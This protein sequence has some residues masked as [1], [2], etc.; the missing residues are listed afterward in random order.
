MMMIIYILYYDMYIYIIWY[1]YIYMYYGGNY[2]MDY[3]NVPTNMLWLIAYYSDIIQTIYIC[4]DDQHQQ[5]LRI[6]MS[7]FCVV[8][9]NVPTLPK[10]SCLFPTR[11]GESPKHG[12]F[13][14]KH[15]AWFCSIIQISKDADLFFLGTWVPARLWDTFGAIYISQS[16]SILK[17]WS[18]FNAVQGLWKISC[19][20]SSTSKFLEG[21]H[22]KSS[23]WVS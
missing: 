14:P 7:F 8:S 4:I 18:H 10:W 16:I 19:L 1:V 12:S 23:L 11:W 15:T 20:R 5:W 2:S 3:S 13:L 21:L 22:Q 17:H 9:M 6:N